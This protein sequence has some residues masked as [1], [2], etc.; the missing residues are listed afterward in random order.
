MSAFWI[1]RGLHHLCSTI[2]LRSHELQIDGPDEPAKR[3][4]IPAHAQPVI[5]ASISLESPPRVVTGRK[6]EQDESADDDRPGHEQPVHA[7]RKAQRA[8]IGLDALHEDHCED[9]SEQ[10][11][12]CKPEPS[13]RADAVITH[14][15]SPYSTRTVYK[16]IRKW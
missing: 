2:A 15:V 5:D 16:S 13:R 4:L 3:A 6:P 11:R 14:V 1:E 8:S 12:D 9:D 7:K 10:R